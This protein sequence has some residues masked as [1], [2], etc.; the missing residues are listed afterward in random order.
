MSLPFNKINQVIPSTFGRWTKFSDL[1]SK[2]IFLWRYIS[3]NLVSS[4]IG[5]GIENNYFRS[6]DP[7]IFKNKKVNIFKYV[8]FKICGTNYLSD[9][10]N[11]HPN[12]YQKWHSTEN[13]VKILL[14]QLI[15]KPFN[16]FLFLSK[17]CRLGP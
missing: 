7:L 12:I 16:T 1:S 6:L 4:C 11:C 13:N 5:A 8:V 9:T 3:K 17:S 14:S 2:Y 10:F 15:G